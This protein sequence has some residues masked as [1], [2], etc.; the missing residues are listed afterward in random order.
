MPI[1]VPTMYLLNNIRQIRTPLE[2]AQNLSKLL[3]YRMFFYSLFG[4]S[5]ILGNTEFGDIKL[6]EDKLKYQI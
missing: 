3:S 1:S 2:N 6:L 5:I 4:G